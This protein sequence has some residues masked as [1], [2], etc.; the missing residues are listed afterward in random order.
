MSQWNIWH[1][2]CKEGARLLEVMKEKKKQMKDAQTGETA[3]TTLQ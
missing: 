3:V 2:R 1:P